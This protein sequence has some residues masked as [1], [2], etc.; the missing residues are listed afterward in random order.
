[1]TFI[2]S[3]DQTVCSSVQLITR[4]IPAIKTRKNSAI[5]FIASPPTTSKAMETLAIAV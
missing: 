5:N 4:N 2:D 1:M 3:G